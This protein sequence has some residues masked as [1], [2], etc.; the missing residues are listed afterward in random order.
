MV[1]L[2]LGSLGDAAWDDVPVVGLGAW[3]VL[4]E[5]SASYEA[6]CPPKAVPPCIP[7]TNSEFH[8]VDVSVFLLFL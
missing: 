5:C 8:S 4:G 6:R 1:V 2:M 7:S 3:R